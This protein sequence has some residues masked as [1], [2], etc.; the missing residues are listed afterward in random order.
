MN[1]NIYRKGVDAFWMDAAEPDIYSNL[2]I[3]ERKEL[4]YP[5]ALGS[6]TKYFNAYPFVNAKVI[7]EGQRSM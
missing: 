2:S 6:A 4:M 1:D 7:Y 3:E 5:N